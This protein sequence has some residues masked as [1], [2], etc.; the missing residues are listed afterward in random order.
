M[1]SKLLHLASGKIVCGY[2]CHYFR[3][4]L[5]KPAASLSALIL[6]T[7]MF[8]GN[9]SAYPLAS[10]TALIIVSTYDENAAI[11]LSTVSVTMFLVTL[12]KDPGILPKQVTATII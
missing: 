10:N 11:V 6:L 4:S 12:L 9:L 8:V 3:S 5:L 1:D 7:G 2:T